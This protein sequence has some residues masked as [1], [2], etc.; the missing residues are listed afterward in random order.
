M[1]MSSGVLTQVSVWPCDCPDFGIF[2]YLNSFIS[3]C[4]L[5][6]FSDWFS[7]VMGISDIM[8]FFDVFISL[9]MVF[10]EGSW[11]SSGLGTIEIKGSL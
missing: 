10:V 1:L 8:D 11:S 7:S 5:E 4:S 9:G 6:E 3:I 2:V